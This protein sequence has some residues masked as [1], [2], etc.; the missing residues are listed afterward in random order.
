MTKEQ[1]IKVMKNERECV[2]RQGS[3]ACR[4]NQDPIRG[5]YGCDLLLDDYDIV[6]AYDQVI[7]SLECEETKT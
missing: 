1:I 4:R 6:E 3:R 2:L 5:C 7:H